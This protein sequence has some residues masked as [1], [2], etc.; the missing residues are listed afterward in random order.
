MTDVALEFLEIDR[1]RARRW[2]LGFLLVFIAHVLALVGLPD[3]SEPI[4]ITLPV[5]AI[6]VAFM[7][8]APPPPPPTPEPVVEEPPI[9]AIEVPKAEPIVQKKPERKK[10][11]KR[12]KPK[13]QPKPR[14]EPVQPSPEPAADA[15]APVPNAV[16]VDRPIDTG[17]SKAS[18]GPPPNYTA[19]LAAW[20]EHYKKYPQRARQR[21]LEGD[22]VLTFVVN[23]N[24]KVPSYEIKKSSGYDVLDRAVEDMIRRAQPLPPIPPEWSQD[25]MELSIPISFKLR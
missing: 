13:P 15:P 3:H 4:P 16:K 11:V 17:A 20:L 10:P 21:G 18:A 22:V 5:P 19:I 1:T 12:E 24:G 6:Q 14:D 25:S 8:A 2:L 9:K 23:R 7:Q